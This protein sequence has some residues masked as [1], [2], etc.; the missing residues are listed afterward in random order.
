MPAPAPVPVVPAATLAPGAV[1]GRLVGGAGPGTPPPRT[2]TLRG[3]RG[4]VIV[5]AAVAVVVAGI[6]DWLCAAVDK[7]ARGAGRRPLPTLRLKAPRDCEGGAVGAGAEDCPDV[8]VGK[9]I[10]DA[11]PYFLTPSGEKGLGR[12]GD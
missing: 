7:S 5:V 4:L 1:A 11:S 10:A 2:K 8:V 12:D 9:P 6:E 3:R